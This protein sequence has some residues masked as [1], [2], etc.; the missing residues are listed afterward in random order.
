MFIYKDILNNTKTKETFDTIGNNILTPLAQEKI[1]QVNAE[2]MSVPCKVRMDNGQDFEFKVGTKQLPWNAA[3]NQPNTCTLDLSSL[4][5]ADIQTNCSQ[6]NPELFDGNSS[7]GVVKSIYWND[8]QANPK[9][10]IKFKD[11]PSENNMTTFWHKQPS[12]IKEAT[13][14][15]AFKDVK[16]LTAET[17]KL[18]S[19]IA[20]SEARIE[21]QEEIIRQKT[22][23]LYS[24]NSKIQGLE[25]DNIN[26]RQDLKDVQQS[27]NNAKQELADIQ[28]EKQLLDIQK[29]TMINDYEKKLLDDK[30][31]A[32]K[33]KEDQARA[34]IDS[35]AADL[36]YRSETLAAKDT[37]IKNNRE[38][39][40]NAEAEATSKKVEL[41]NLKLINER[42][43]QLLNSKTATLNNLIKYP[44]Y[45]N[46]I[47]GNTCITARCLT[48]PNSKYKACQ[49]GD[50]HFVIYNNYTGAPIYATGKYGSQF[51]NGSL[52]IQEDG[53]LVNYY[54]N[55]RGAYWA[56]NTWTQSPVGPYSAEMLD[57]GDFVV[58]DRDNNIKW[59]S[60]SAGR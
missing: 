31:A 23:E 51:T 38:A 40:N 32:L 14:Q 36:K 28:E 3:P 13:C 53:N 57:S 52:C 25:Q 60:R 1:G 24:L 8:I 45:A 5:L 2:I 41:D 29:Q 58:K 15:K 22:N 9:C 11:A 47:V 54:N 16:D 44:L 17:N 48:S 10:E 42:N 4:E 35:H 34:I 37:E 43:Q 56:T 21:I 33:L 26:L 50:G 7:T 19:D 12:Y 55:G 30:A 27:L 6:N 46:K 59:S 39:A 49:Q 20:E 18:K